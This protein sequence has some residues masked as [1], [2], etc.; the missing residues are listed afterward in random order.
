[1]KTDICIIGAGPA[2]L[3]AAIGAATEEAATIL[4]EA[5][6]NAGCKLL[7]TGGGRCNFTHAATIDELVRAFG[8]S[9]RFLRH[10]FH[11]L[12]PA[13]IRIFFDERGVPSTIEPDGCVFPR[14][15]R[16]TDIRAALVQEAEKL[17]AHTRCASRVTQVVAGAP[18]FQIDTKGQSILAQRVIIA[19][20]GLSWPQTG[21]TGDGYQFAADL[22]HAIVEAKPALVPLVTREKWPA[23][24]AGLSVRDIALRAKAGGRKIAAQG[25]LVFTY[26][27]LGGPAPQDLSRALADALVEQRDGVAI[28]L[29]LTPTTE[30]AELDQRLQEKLAG[31]TK[32]TLA[33][34]LVEFVPK[35][36]AATLCTLA[37]DEAG[38]PANQVR[39]QTRR[40]LTAL[41]KS[42]PL[43]VTGT[44]PIAEATVTRGGINRDQIERRTLESKIRPGLY[45][46]GEVI[47]ADGPCGGY[48]LHMCFATGL[49]AGRSAAHSIVNP[50]PSEV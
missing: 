32:K 41:I 6:A 30:E 18:G 26:D 7:A 40:R 42:V 3:M 31:H 22:G 44:R 27:G 14:T 1:M 25:N 37:N 48:N 12:T 36:L 46:A 43:V 15:G 19:T 35:R 13:D 16:A 8:K 2:G 45:F 33:N 10:S 39:K 34:I 23:D 50:T 21:S 24:L 49:L 11:E 5:N 9:G 20:G 29:D 4:L 38:R 47:D 17:G 28:R